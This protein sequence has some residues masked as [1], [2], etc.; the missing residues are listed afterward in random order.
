MTT[1]QAMI[2]AQ[3]EEKL[4]EVILKETEIIHNMLNKDGAAAKYHY[5]KLDIS[6]YLMSY[7]KEISGNNTN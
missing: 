2:I 5:G 3:I 1:D 6:K 4:E 7:I